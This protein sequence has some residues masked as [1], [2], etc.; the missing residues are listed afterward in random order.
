MTS[1]ETKHLKLY[2][3]YNKFIQKFPLGTNLFNFVF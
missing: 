1:Y 2:V 3:K